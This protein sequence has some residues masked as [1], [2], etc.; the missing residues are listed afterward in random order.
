MTDFL[1][2]TVGFL[3]RRPVVVATVADAAATLDLNWPDPRNP[4][5]LRAAELLGKAQAGVC[6][7]RVAF[8]A[9]RIAVARQGLLMDSSRSSA[10]QVLDSLAAESLVVPPQ[11]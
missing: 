5:Y 1:P 3:G 10:L 6:Q 2:L 8:E 4:A 11:S 7:P 9:Y